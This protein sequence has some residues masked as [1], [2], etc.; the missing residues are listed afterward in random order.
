MQADSNAIFEAALNLP[1][2]ERLALVSR[3]LET[4][5]D[6]P[7]GLSLDDPN[8]VE[9]LKRRSADTEGSVPWS[10]LRDKL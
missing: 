10:Q 6:E 8:L 9:E 1:E 7:A 5:P 3:L 4:V 2:D